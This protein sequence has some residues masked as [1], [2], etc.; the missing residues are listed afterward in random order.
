ME[1][2]RLTKRGAGV[3]V[4]VP[5]GW[6]GGQTDSLTW[7]YVPAINIRNTYMLRVDLKIGQRLAVQIAKDTRL[8]ALRSAEEQGNLQD[9]EIIAET[10]DSFEATY[11]DD[12]YRRVTMERWVGDDNDTAYADIAV[13]GRVAD[14]EGLRDL[15]VRVAESAQQLDPL[16]PKEKDKDRGQGQGQG[17]GR[18]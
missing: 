8:N 16:P 2:L 17:Q 13:T 5:D 11:I 15:V 4:S 18:G 14:T 3:G 7:T 6:Q 10:D 12:G 9:L 1:E